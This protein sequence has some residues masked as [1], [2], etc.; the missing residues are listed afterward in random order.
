MQ[1]RYSQ[2]MPERIEII[3]VDDQERFRKAILAEL[4]DY[5]ISA[6]SQANN[7]NE[8][9]EQLSNSNPDVVVLDLE[10]PQ[11]DGSKTFDHIKEKFPNTKVLILS[12]HDDPGIMDNYIHRGVNGYLPKSFVSSDVEVLAKGIKAVKNNETFY[13]SF[14]PSNPLK[15]TKRE[16]QIIPLLY[17]CKTSKEIGQI[18]GIEEKQVNKLRHQLHKKTNSR[19]A[20]EFIKY[21]VERGL[22]FLGKK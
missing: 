18:I 20:T 11:M 19:N 14:D 3:L 10:M 17:E 16:T 1:Q 15:Y 7:G 6:I 4:A 12:Q 5:N 9:L 2:N 21:C 13:Y 8:C 22:K